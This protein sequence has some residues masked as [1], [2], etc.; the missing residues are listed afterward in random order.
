MAVIE[1][2]HCEGNTVLVFLIRGIF[3]RGCPVGCTGREYEKA[4]PLKW[5]VQSI[6]HK[7]VQFVSVT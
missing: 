1:N 6:L 5:Y 3:W 7:C 4:I 2:Q